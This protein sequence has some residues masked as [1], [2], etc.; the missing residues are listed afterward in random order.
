MA[1][2]TNFVIYEI[3]IQKRLV[4]ITS[5]SDYVSLNVSQLPKALSYSCCKYSSRS[6]KLQLS[7]TVV[8]YFLSLINLNIK[9]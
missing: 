7:V 6:L 5:S 9:K 4:S 2:K 1:L 8:M 3:K